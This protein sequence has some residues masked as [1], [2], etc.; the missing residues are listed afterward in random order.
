MRSLDWYFPCPYPLHLLVFSSFF[1]PRVTWGIWEFSREKQSEWVVPQ[2]CFVS[3]G[4]KKTPPVLS[5]SIAGGNWAFPLMECQNHVPHDVSVICKWKRAFFLFCHD[6]RGNA[7]KHTCGGNCLTSEWWLWGFV[8]KWKYWL[9]YGNVLLFI[10]VCRNENLEK[11]SW[12]NSNSNIFRNL[13]SCY[14]S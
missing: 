4:E 8:E 12:N 6:K 7:H 9:K 5:W 13:L 3:R 2:P 14:I 1:S 11:N 10:F